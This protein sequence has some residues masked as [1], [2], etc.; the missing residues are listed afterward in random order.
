MMLE[1]RN[2]ISAASEE[3]RNK[4]AN[5]VQV[6]TNKNPEM[7]D[8]KAMTPNPVATPLP[9]ENFIQIE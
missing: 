1:T 3:Y 7:G 2:D 9:P 6:I 5:V 8:R 4:K